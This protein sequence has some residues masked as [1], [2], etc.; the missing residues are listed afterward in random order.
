MYNMV[1]ATAATTIAH[2]L[3]LPNH[4]SSTKAATPNRL[5]KP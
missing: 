1:V 5:Y 3:N 2:P 4:A